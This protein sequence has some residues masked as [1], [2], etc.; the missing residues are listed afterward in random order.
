MMMGV[1]SL[2]L[3]RTSLCFLRHT[4]LGSAESADAV[5][6]DFYPQSEVCSEAESPLF[7]GVE[8]LKKSGL[9]WNG[10]EATPL[11]EQQKEE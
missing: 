4:S 11:V 1:L 10:L 7:F 2:L 6:M 5:L 8:L 3:D 9:F